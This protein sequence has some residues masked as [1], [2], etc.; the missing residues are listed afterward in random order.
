MTDKTLVEKAREERHI[1]ATLKTRVSNVRSRNSDALIAV[2]EGPSDFAPYEVWI[3]S[4][5]PQF[6][7]EFVVGQGKRQVL[8]FRQR[9]KR[10]TTGLRSGTYMFVDHDFDGL[11]GQEPGED[12]YCTKG[13]SVENYLVSKQVLQSILSDDF[14]CKAETHHRDEIIKL[15]ERVFQQFIIEIKEVNRRIFWSNRLGIQGPGIKQPITKFVEIFLCKV[16]RKYDKDKLRKLIKLDREPLE[17]EVKPINVEFG[18]LDPYLNY[19]GKF[20]FEFF[21]KWLSK[22]NEEKNKPDQKLF[23]EDK[24]VKFSLEKIDL[25]SLASRS[26]VPEELKQFVQNMSRTGPTKKTK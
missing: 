8:D 13:Y 7:I 18:K 4:L 2:V 3:N 17:K 24:K 5:K 21:K 22:L 10:D 1:G 25:R 14:Q 11:M 23:L 6:S 9:I 26:K 19:R 15:F 20:M 16:T 12:I